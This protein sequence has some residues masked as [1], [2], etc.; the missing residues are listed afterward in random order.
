[1]FD[2]VAI[3]IITAAAFKRGIYETISLTAMETHVPLYGIT[4]TQCYLPPDR[5]DIP[6]FT[7][8]NYGRYSIL[9]HGEMQ[10]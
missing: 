10:G 6:A 2:A 4:V 3:V 8:P 1:M 5:G 9:C 7:P